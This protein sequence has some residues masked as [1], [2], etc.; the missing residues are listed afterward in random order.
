MRR[1]AQHKIVASWLLLFAF[2]PKTEVPVKEGTGKFWFIHPTPAS[3]P[4]RRTL[5]PVLHPGLDA[6]TPVRLAE[7]PPASR[8][9]RAQRM[10]PRR[11]GGS[12]PVA[13]QESEY[14]QQ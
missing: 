13:R 14:F 10:T 11:A 9:I 6:D 4:P 5:P 3:G 12:V 1:S 7:R 2:R 8:S